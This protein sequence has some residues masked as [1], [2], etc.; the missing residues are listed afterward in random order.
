MHD[1]APICLICK[2][3][4]KPNEKRLR[5]PVVGCTR[6]H[7]DHGPLCPWHG[8]KLRKEWPKQIIIAVLVIVMP[9]LVLGSGIIVRQNRTILVFTQRPTLTPTQH[10]TPTVALTSSPIP[11]QHIGTKPVTTQSPPMST[12]PP[13]LATYQVKAGDTLWD[14]AQRF[15]GD[16]TKWSLI[17]NA[18]NVDDPKRLRIGTILIIPTQP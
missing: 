16:G 2:A 4:V 15:Y 11:T 7:A 14:I 1:E 13:R 3:P 17:A 12:E 5:C 6:F 8:C 18:N 9:L 10:L